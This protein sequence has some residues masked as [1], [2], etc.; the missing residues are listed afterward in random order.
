MNS[1]RTLAR[2][3]ALILSAKTG[4]LAYAAAATD[5]EAGADQLQEITVTAQLRSQNAQNVPITLQTI[6]GSSL[7]QMDVPTIDDFVKYLPNVSTAS[8]APGVSN[9]YMR[10]LSVGGQYSMGTGGVGS[11]PNVA[12]YLDDQSAQIPGRNLDVYGADLERIEVLEGPQ[13][14]LFGS[15][16]EAGVLRY[17]TNKPKL[18]VTEA[19]V[20]AG[21]GYTS[22]GDPN[23]NVEAVL[24]VP[25]IADTL[26]LRAVLY[27]DSRGG[28]INNV[29]GKFTRSNTDLGI[30]YANYPAGCGAGV[31]CEVPP[32]SPVINN[33]SLVGN[34]VNPVTYQGV[35][36]QGLFKANDW[37]VLLSQTYQTINAQGVFYE[38]PNGSDG[39]QLPDLSVQLFNPSFNKDRFENTALTVNGKIGDL[40]LVYTGSYLV[41]NAEQ[42]QD[43]TNYA[44][45]VYGDYYQCIPG[46]ATTTATC[47]SPSATW[48]EVMRDTHDSQ[49]LRLSTPD[50]WRLRAIGGVFWEDY[51]VQETIDFGYKTAPGFAPIVPPAGSTSV[52]P[53]VRNSNIAFFDDITRG[54]KQTA[55]FGSVDFDVIPK[56]LTVTVGTRY[57]HFANSEVG[58]TAGSFGCYVG[59]TTT[60][61]CSS[62]TNLDAENLRSTY[63]GF[64]SRAN[65]SWHI[66]P[67]VLSYYTWS[68]GFRPG[69]FNRTSADHALAGGFVF[70]TPQGFAPDSLTNNELGWKTEWLGHHLQFNGALYQE[71]WKNVQV[72]FFDPQGGLGNLTFLTNGPNYRIRG[73]ETQLVALVHG[74]TISGSASWNSSNQTNSP[75]LLATKGPLAGQPITS[76]PNPYGPLNSPTAESP[77]FQGNLRVRYDLTLNDYNVFVQAGGQHQAHSYSATGNVEGF[78]QSAYTTYDASLGVAKNAWSVQVIGQNL[79]DTRADLFTNSTLFI[80]AVSVNRPRTVGVRMSYKF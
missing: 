29:P 17:I 19:S 73:V 31:R 69:G 37:S 47:Y 61:P 52:N 51:S 43:Y 7:T 46:T 42:I 26:A 76:I 38:T 54:Y 71:D 44:R 62:G 70:T 18:N 28:F 65:V 3:I 48:H 59:V 39:E 30:H 63:S 79:T 53:D 15:G 11:F 2:A 60:T 68:Q 41:H 27:D 49:E 78:D 23:T 33:N 14:T 20:D 6:S 66:L 35:R 45:G 22:H 72:S 10:G 80:K 13:G 36:A 50:D 21:Y 24:N 34:A 4:E 58:S 56:S 12:I 25:V 55:A 1:G 64:K 40:N 74:F 8:F 67:D 32:G 5:A 57:Y 77:P 16:S 9:I 75:Y